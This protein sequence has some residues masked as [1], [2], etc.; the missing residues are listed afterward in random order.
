MRTVVA[1]G[2]AASLIVLAGCGEESVTDSDSDVLVLDVPLDLDTPPDG[3]DC[4]NV[5]WMSEEEVEDGIIVRWSSALA[6]Y[7]Y[8]V[9]DDYFAAVT[10]EV[11]GATA[12]LSDESGTRAN[13]NT[14]TPRGRDPAEGNLLSSNPPFTVEMTAMHAAEDDDD[15]DGVIDWMGEIGT[16][17]LWL[18]LD[19]EGMRKAVKLGVNIH[20]E[21]PDEGAGFSSRCPTG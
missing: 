16:G 17:H 20:L 8:A 9:T 12:T 21:D 5:Y 18:Q 6:G 2:L 10:W 14:W 13:G 15:G 19:L 11:E 1:L 7:D 3:G 4:P